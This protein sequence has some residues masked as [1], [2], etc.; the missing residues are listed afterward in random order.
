MPVDDC[1]TGSGYR[2]PHGYRVRYRRELGRKEYDHRWALMQLHV[3][4]AG[5]QVQHLCNNRECI[6]PEH[7]TVGTHRQ[8]MDYMLACGR[9]KN[10][11]LEGDAHP[12]TV[13]TGKDRE[14]IRLLLAAGTH[15]QLKI[16]EM[17]GVSQQTVSNIKRSQW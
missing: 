8:N 2:L 17:F 1:I 15:S 11:W 6:N 13:T 10:G 14:A 12:N 5:M 3:P 16:A 4:I 7:L 9:Q